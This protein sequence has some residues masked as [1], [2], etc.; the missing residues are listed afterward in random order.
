MSN[1]LLFYIEYVVEINKHVV[2]RDRWLQP[3]FS[4]LRYTLSAASSTASCCVRWQKYSLFGTF[5]FSPAKLQKE[6]CFFLFLWPLTIFNVALCMKRATLTDQCNNNNNC[7]WVIGDTQ[8][9]WGL[10]TSRWRYIHSDVR[11]I[12]VKTCMNICMWAQVTNT[13]LN[14]VMSYLSS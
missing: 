2:I 14:W 6:K 4:D 1:K 13:K 11:D 8:L 7:S 5:S 10:E 3:L 9:Q 12:Y